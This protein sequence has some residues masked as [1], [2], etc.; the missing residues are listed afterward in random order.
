MRLCVFDFSTLIARFFYI[1]LKKIPVYI[2]NIRLTIT[3]FRSA[4]IPHDD[5]ALLKRK[6]ACSFYSADFFLFFLRDLSLDTAHDHRLYLVLILISVKRYSLS[7]SC[8]FVRISA[9]ILGGS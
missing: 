6:K 4:I 5:S 3:L 8:P 2:A 7:G 1:L 9:R